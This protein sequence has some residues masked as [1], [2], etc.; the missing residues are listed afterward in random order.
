MIEVREFTGGL[1]GL[2]QFEDR[3][4]MWDTLSFGLVEEEYLQTQTYISALRKVFD[5][6]AVEFRAFTVP[7]HEVFDWYT[8]R[9]QCLWRKYDEFTLS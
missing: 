8:S 7:D 5:N 6:G 4:Q 1:N 3:K 2:P 9:N